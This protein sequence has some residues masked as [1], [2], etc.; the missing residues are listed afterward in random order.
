[1]SVE[2]SSQ[3]ILS[4][5]LEEKGRETGLLVGLEVEAN[6]VSLETVSSSKTGIL[7]IEKL[8]SDVEPHWNGSI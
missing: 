8:A 6:V 4:R 7:T 5:G 3:K 1:M 2:R